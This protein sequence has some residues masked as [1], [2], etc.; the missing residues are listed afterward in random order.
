MPKTWAV[1]DLHGRMDLYEKINSFIGEK[2]IVYFLGDANDRGPKGYELMKAIYNNP[3]WIY[4]LG[5]HEDMFLDACWDYLGKNEWDYETY[6]QCV[7][8]GGLNVLC[9]WE[10]EDP[11]QRIVWYNRFN[12]LAESAEYINI[13]GQTIL[14][15]HAGFTPLWN[16]H[17]QKVVYSDDRYRLLWDRN[18]IDDVRW[19]ENGDNYFVVHGHTPVKYICPDRAPEEG[20]LKYCHGHKFDIDIGCYKTG[21]TV[22]FDLDE[23]QGIVITEDKN[24]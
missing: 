7:R 10:E 15:S 16:R 23:L 17:L 8:N 19:V 5:N 9:S 21:A 1:S 18:H 12:R 2:D 13:H 6:V 3:N 11:T 4:L 20:E 24:G 22:L 14:L